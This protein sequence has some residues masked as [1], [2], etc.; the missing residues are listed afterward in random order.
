MNQVLFS[1]NMS[2]RYISKIFCLIILKTTLLESIRFQL[3]YLFSDVSLRSPKG[4]SHLLGV[5]VSLLYI[6][7]T[8]QEMTLDLLIIGIMLS[9]SILIHFYTFSKSSCITQFGKITQTSFTFSKPAME[10]PE[11]CVKSVQN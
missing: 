4:H 11:Q 6:L 1:K 9:K 7:T 5:P 10:T 8:C 2:S 3:E